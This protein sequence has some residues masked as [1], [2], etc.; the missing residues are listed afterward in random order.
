MN[1]Q[2]GNAIT[3]H[4]HLVNEMCALRQMYDE[5]RRIEEQAKYA[6]QLNDPRQVRQMLGAIAVRASKYMAG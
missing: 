4:V 2:S 3:E 6:Q 1:S 5:A